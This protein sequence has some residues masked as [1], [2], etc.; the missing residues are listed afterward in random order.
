MVQGKKDWEKNWDKIDTLVSVVKDLEDSWKIIKTKYNL[1]NVDCC[2]IL[3]MEDDK[4]T[5]K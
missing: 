3:K 5:L 1:D 4:I 2:I